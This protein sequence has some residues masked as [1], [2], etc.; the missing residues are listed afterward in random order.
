LIELLNRVDELEERLDHFE[1]LLRKVRSRI[2]SDRS[3]EVR[4]NNVN[5]TNAQP[6]TDD[7]Y[8]GRW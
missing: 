7:Y 1:K 5:T 2:A 8:N 3:V 4:E 6:T